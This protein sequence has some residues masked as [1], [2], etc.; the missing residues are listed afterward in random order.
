MAEYPIFLA[1]NWMQRREFAICW[2]RHY[3]YQHIFAAIII[4]AIV[5]HLTLTPP[6]TYCIYNDVAAAMIK[7]I[8]IFSVTRHSGSDIVTYLLTYLLIVSTDLT[9]VTLVSDD[10]Y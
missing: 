10:T 9:D 6:T 1:L 7:I 3:Y 5:N 4:A 2:Q 8:Y